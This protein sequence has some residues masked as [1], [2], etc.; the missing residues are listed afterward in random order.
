MEALSGAE[1]KGR[2]KQ[3]KKTKE[4]NSLSGGF[5]TFPQLFLGPNAYENTQRD[6]VSAVLSGLDMIHT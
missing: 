6:A 3:K 4:E 2:D 5:A 1:S